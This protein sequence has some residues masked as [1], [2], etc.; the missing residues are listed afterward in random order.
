MSEAGGHANDARGWAT[1]GHSSDVQ[2]GHGP[3]S[4]TDRLIFVDKKSIG[5]RESAASTSSYDKVDSV[6]HET[7]A[8]GRRHHDIRL[9][10]QGPSSLNTVH[11]TG[12]SALFDAT[13]KPKD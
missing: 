8:D 3:L 10:Q 4:A 13:S 7:K 9:G 2:G 12:L 1:G 11:A 6:Q 5:K